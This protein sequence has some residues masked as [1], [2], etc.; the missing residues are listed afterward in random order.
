M[1]NYHCYK[2]PVLGI[3]MRNRIWGACSVFRTETMSTKF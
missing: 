2:L 1:T 3:R